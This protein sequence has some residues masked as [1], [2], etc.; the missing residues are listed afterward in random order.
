MDDLRTQLEQFNR[1]GLADVERWMTNK[2]Q[3]R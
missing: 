2:L 3:C 1:Q